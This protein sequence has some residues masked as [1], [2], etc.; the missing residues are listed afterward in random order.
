M[1]FL[2]YKK[3]YLSRLKLF[4][5]LFYRNVFFFEVGSIKLTTQQIKSMKNFMNS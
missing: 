5:A 1:I 4:D 3:Y 2:T